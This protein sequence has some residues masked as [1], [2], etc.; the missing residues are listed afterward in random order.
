VTFDLDHTLDAHWPVHCVQ[1]WWRSGHLPARRSDLRKSLQTDRRRTPRHCISS[2]LEWAKNCTQLVATTTSSHGDLQWPENVKISHFFLS[3]RITCTS[4][5]R[6]SGYYCKVGGITYTD[7][8]TLTLLSI[9]GSHLNGLS[10]FSEVNATSM[11]K[12]KTYHTVNL[13]LVTAW[14]SFN[15]SSL[16]LAIRQKWINNFGMKYDFRPNP[17]WRPAEVCTPWVLSSSLYLTL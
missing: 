1:V 14:P 7:P 6:L 11:L 15:I 13:P 5:I 3:A 12:I 16:N 10:D 2:F 8:M 17:R 9:T 4:G